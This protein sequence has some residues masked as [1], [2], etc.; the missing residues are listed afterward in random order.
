M[1]MIKREKVANVKIEIM[2]EKTTELGNI[3]AVDG[4]AIRSTSKKGEAN[5]ALQILTAYLTESGVTL[6]QESIHKKTN[7]IPV[8]QDM[9]DYL[10]IKGKVITADALHC[11]RETCKKIIEKGGDYVFGLKE[12][13]KTLYDNI[14][15]FFTDS[16][17]NDNISVYESIEKNHGRI[18][19]RICRKATSIEWLDVE[20]KWV[21]LKT[22]FEVRR[23]VTSKN[24]TSIETSYYISSHDTSAKELLKIS[25]EHWKIESL[26]W[27]LDVVFSEDECAVIS[28]NGQKTLNIFRKL[29]L[30]LH[31][32]F[33]K[34]QSKKSSIKAS[35]LQALVSDKRIL[36]ILRSL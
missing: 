9:L 31:K 32:N 14:K 21:G 6:G 29:A 28:D 36:E 24:S 12:N 13:Q 4:K 25:R 20:N 34:Q 5:S 18:E 1:N 27:L 35:I 10:E 2:K 8:F 11:Q 15:L 3:I 17:N 19:K 23:E 16:I 7:E 33:I 22:V 30:L 26:H